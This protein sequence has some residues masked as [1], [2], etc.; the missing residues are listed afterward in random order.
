MLSACRYQQFYSKSNFSLSP[1][2]Q[3]STRK[4]ISVLYAEGVPFN[5]RISIRLIRTR[6]NRAHFKK[7]TWPDYW[8]KLS[9]VY[10]TTLKVTGAI[11]NRAR[12]STFHLKSEIGMLA[13]LHFA[14][15]SLQFALWAVYCSSWVR[16]VPL[17][18]QG[19]DLIGPAL[20][21]LQLNASPSHSFFKQLDHR[22]IQVH[23]KFSN[24][25][26]KLKKMYQT[27]FA[28]ILVK[29]AIHKLNNTHPH[30]HKQQ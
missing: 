29:F 17:H 4:F 18:L 15:L 13:A 9:V 25:A 26:H 6:H 14:A 7:G 10:G 27:K 19:N 11:D 28:L 5:Q 3:F 21:P 2:I 12:L 23:W 16:N 1:S 8:R 24:H 20:F 30:N 22:I